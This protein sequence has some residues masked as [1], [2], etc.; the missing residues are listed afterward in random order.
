MAEKLK[1]P[2]L[3]QAIDDQSRAT[4]SLSPLGGV[5]SEMEQLYRA[6]A[7]LPLAF[8][9]V[10][11]LDA[12]E[13]GKL[14]VEICTQALQADKSLGVVIKKIGQP[15]RDDRALRQN[16]D[17]NGRPAMRSVKRGQAVVIRGS[18]HIDA[19]DVAPVSRPE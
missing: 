19:M 13:R 14:I 11:G 7:D 5:L 4:W 18:Q 3:K 16:A 1:P 8:D 15:L 2:K 9:S 12:V 6:H 10:V 17:V